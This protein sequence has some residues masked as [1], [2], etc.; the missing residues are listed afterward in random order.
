MNKPATM[1]IKEFR[2][3]F[4][5]VL[6]G[7]GLPWWKVLD[8]IQNVYLPLLRRAAQDEEHM[9]FEKYNESLKEEQEIVESIR[10]KKRNRKGGK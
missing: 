4:E 10:R 5:E 6:N 8:E 9:E 2:A 7:S 3:K 1:L